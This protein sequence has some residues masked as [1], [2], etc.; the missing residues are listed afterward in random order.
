MK[1]DIYQGAFA[2]AKKINEVEVKSI[3]DLCSVLEALYQEN[4]EAKVYFD[5]DIIMI[6]CD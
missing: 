2:V 3:Q 5:G 1:I 6:D 4:D